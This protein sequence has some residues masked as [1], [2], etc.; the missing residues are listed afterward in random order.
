MSFSHSTYTVN[1]ADGSIEV[2]LVLTNPVSFNVP[3]TVFN[4][5]GSAT[6]KRIVHLFVLYKFCNVTMYN[7]C[8]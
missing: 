2:L 5:D 1:E 8:I 4:A 6:G 7:Y 3:V